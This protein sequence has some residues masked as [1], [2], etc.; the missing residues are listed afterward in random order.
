MQRF[1]F[2]AN[3]N[4]FRPWKYAFRNTVRKRVRCTIP[5][6]TIDSAAYIL[7]DW[8]QTNIILEQIF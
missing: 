8:R 3:L 7:L 5:E 1:V 4:D 6:R 2:I